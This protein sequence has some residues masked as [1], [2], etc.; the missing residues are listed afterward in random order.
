MFLWNV[1]CTEK[2]FSSIQAFYKLKFFQAFRRFLMQNTEQNN[3]K[4]KIKSRLLTSFWW[5]FGF[6]MV[7]MLRDITTRGGGGG[8]SLTTFTKPGFMAT[9]ST[10]HQ[11]TDWLEGSKETTQ[12]TFTLFGITGKNCLTV[13]SKRV[14]V[15]YIQVNPNNTLVTQY[16]HLPQA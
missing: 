10:L 4:P 8:R 7:F 15:G 16:S 13:T 5:V 9:A 12:T 14:F 3:T 1:G 6:W 2:L 11:L